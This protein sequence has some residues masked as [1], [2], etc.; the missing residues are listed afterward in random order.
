MSTVQQ[1][2]AE[3]KSDCQG[4]HQSDIIS[5]TWCIQLKLQI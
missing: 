5:Q 3:S 2:K 1:R 4:L